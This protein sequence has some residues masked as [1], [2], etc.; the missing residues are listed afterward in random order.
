MDQT[1]ETHCCHT[2][3]PNESK[4]HSPQAGPS[5]P[6]GFR[7]VTLFLLPTHGLGSMLVTFKS[8]SSPGKP[9]KKATN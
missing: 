9:F 1:R 3:I 5:V 8:V 4:L 2:S 6:S 7:T